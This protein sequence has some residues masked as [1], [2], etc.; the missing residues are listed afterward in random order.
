[1]PRV[2]TICTHAER[3][4]IEA[5]LLADQPLRDIAGRTGTTKSALDRHR[6]HIAKNLVRAQGAV[7]MSRVDDLL[8]RVQGLVVEADAI[9]R[10]ARGNGEGRNPELAL[11]AIDRLTKLTELFARLAGELRE[12]ATVNVAIVQAPEWAALRAR[13]LAALAPHPDA[14]AAVLRAI[15]VT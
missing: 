7:E 12:G 5:A 14:R 4:A 6:D 8:G 9:L 10:E 1:M 13:I 11:K 3:P 15:D 2:C